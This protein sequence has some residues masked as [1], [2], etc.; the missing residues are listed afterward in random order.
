[1]LRY[2]DVVEE[3]YNVGSSG[4]RRHAFDANHPAT[5]DTAY[6]AHP[7]IVLKHTWYMFTVLENI[8]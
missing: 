1:M 8:V 3:L 7:A 6:S 4:L 5:R 2:F